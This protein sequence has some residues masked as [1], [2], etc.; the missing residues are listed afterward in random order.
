MTGPDRRGALPA[1]RQWT[2]L[3]LAPALWLV[4]FLLA[5]LVVEA[6]CSEA[7]RLEPDAVWGWLLGGGIAFALAAAFAT[8]AAWRAARRAAR[9]D[10]DWDDFLPRVGVKI[11]LLVVGVL[12]VETLMLFFV[13]VCG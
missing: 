6:T 1:R 5:Y 4:H 7:T 2:G 13:E 11:G 10:P 8:F 3:L 12:A 9:D